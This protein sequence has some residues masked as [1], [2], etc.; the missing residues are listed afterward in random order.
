MQAVP[1]FKI[2]PLDIIT[3]LL[4]HL[5]TCEMGLAKIYSYTKFDISSFTI[6]DLGKG[7]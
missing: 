7:V 6:P 2:R 1:K 5:V 4:R 3:P